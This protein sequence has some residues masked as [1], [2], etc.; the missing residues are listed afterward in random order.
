LKKELSQPTE[1]LMEYNRNSLIVPNKI[2]ATTNM[3]NMN[4]LIEEVIQLRIKLKEAN[5]VNEDLKE[6]FK[7]N[8][9]QLEHTLKE[10]IE[11]KERLMNKKY[12][13]T[14]YSLINIFLKIIFKKE[15][16]K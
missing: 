11:D 14:R 1:S 9:S 5:S 16:Q 2:S 6:S 10:C 8:L 13:I 3:N 12:L 15:I 4:N 7:K